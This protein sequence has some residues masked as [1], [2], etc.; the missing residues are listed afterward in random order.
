[1]KY[2]SMYTNTSNAKAIAGLIFVTFATT[3]VVLYTPQIC[4]GIIKLAKKGKEKAEVLINGQK[5]VPVVEQKV[6]GY[7]YTDGKR[8]WFGKK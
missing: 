5:A 8:F 7:V 6:D 2:Q 1:M 3:A 4:E